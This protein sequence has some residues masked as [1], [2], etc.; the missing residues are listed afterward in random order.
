MIRMSVKKRLLSA[1]GPMDLEIDIELANGEIIAIYGASGVGKTTVLRMLCGL[2]DPDEGFIS[3]DGNAWFDSKNKINLKPQ[4]RNIGIVFQDYALFPN[5]TVQENLTYALG[6][7]QP[8]SEVDELL[9]LMELSNFKDKHPNVLSGG[10]R[11]RVAL[12]R[13]LVRKPNI[14]LLDEP[15]SALD[16]LLR[17]KIQDYILQVHQQ[18]NLTTLLVSHDILEV[19]RLSRRVLLMEEG[20]ITR[21]GS[22]QNILPLHDWKKMLDGI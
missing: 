9:D 11:Q 20:K 17:L 5:M 1:N 4:K 22:P 21:Q 19:V 8:S 14:L 12:A 18:F 7:K 13:A 6:R 2:T 10:Q 16:T 15:L 3:V